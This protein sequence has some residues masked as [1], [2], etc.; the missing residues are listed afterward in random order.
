[1]IYVK[2]RTG[3]VWLDPMTSRFEDD[4]ETSPST[5]SGRIS[6]PVEKIYFPRMPCNMQLFFMTV[7][8]ISGAA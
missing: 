8:R 6:R 2:M 5:Q 1:M 7:I 4:I 3:F